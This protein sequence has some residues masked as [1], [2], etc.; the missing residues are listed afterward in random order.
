MFVRTL[1][2]SAALA[3]VAVPILAQT[4]KKTTAHAKS[5]AS[6]APSVAA[7]WRVAYHDT[8]VTV[9]IDTSA[10]RK[11][12]DGFFQTHLKWVYASD[13]GIDHNKK[14]Y[15][16]LVEDRLLDC[17]YVQTKPINATVYDAN[18][19]VVNSFTTPMSDVQYM[20]WSR[21]KA[22]T[23]NERALTAVCRMLRPV[24]KRAA[25]KAKA[26]SKKK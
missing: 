26:A 25:A 10:T 23:P 5:T 24:S 9:T 12:A 8:Q 18:G 7:P 22:G 4:A 14:S 11:T 20:S 13:Q 21:R 16:T 6:V 1:T 17:D 19:K 15:R 3:L 2:F